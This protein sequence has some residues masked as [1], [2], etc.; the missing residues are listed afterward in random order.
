MDHL[1]HLDQLDRHLHHQY[2]K[3]DPQAILRVLVQVFRD[4]RWV[5][6]SLIFQFWIPYFFNMKCSIR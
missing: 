1:A 5:V 2:Q 4:L 6:A 3:L